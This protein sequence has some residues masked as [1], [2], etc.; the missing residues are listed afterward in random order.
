[1]HYND[2]GVFYTVY[3]S[4]SMETAR[5]NGRIFVNDELCDA[6]WEAVKVALRD[7]KK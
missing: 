3:L 2:S 6:L 7:E 1:M 4:W 5:L